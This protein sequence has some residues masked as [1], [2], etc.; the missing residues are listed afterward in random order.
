MSKRERGCE[1]RRKE[2][3]GREGKGM[4]NGLLDVALGPGVVWS[5][6][7]T[8]VLSCCSVRDLSRPCGM[9]QVRNTG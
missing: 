3:S 4:V 5:L 2:G 8:A 6:T 1:S 7:P 9:E